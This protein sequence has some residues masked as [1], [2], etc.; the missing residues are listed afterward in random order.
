MTPADIVKSTIFTT[1]VDA[2]IAVIGPETQRILGS[3]LPASTLI[4][5]S[6]LA[7]PELKIEIEVTA[8]R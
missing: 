2:C 7:F 6:R 8:A 5:V 4:G 3:N 1:D